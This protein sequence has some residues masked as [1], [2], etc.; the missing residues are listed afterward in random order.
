MDR[1]DPDDSP[2]IALAMSI[3]NEGIW[4]DDKHFM[5]QDAIKIW[6]TAQLFEYVK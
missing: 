4:S 6:K 1:I 2:F 5:V 3:E